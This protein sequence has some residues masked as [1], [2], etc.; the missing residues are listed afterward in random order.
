MAKTEKFLLV[1]KKSYIFKAW[2]LNE[3]I[4]F[5]FFKIN[6]YAINIWAETIIFLTLWNS[7]RL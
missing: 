3:Q 2:L 4:H 6:V 1:P 5:I 7:F